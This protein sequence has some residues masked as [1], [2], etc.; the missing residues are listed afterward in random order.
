MKV[1]SQP[2]GFLAGSLFRP[3]AR[4]CQRIV[5]CCKCNSVASACLGT[6]KRLVGVA[7]KAH[8]VE[9]FC[10]AGHG[11]A[12]TECGEYFTVRNVDGLLTDRSSQTFCFLHCRVR[13]ASRKNDQKLLAT[14]PRNRIVDSYRRTYPPCGFTQSGVASQVA[15][16]VVDSLK[17]VQVRHD[18]SQGTFRAPS[19]GDFGV[20]CIESRRAVSKTRQGIM[21]RLEAERISRRTITSPH[22]KTGGIGSREVL[23]LVCAFA[24]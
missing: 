1:M 23:D 5:G 2:K 11:N 6:V 20:E 19:P 22:G 17:V 9:V 13:V 7:K 10:S 18:D 15:V 24:P 14:V 3:A 8:W 16:R 21:A 4:A 12:E